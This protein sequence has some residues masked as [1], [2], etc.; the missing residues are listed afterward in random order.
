MRVYDI[1]NA[2][3]KHRFM[4][5][6]HIVSNCGRIVQLQN[7]PQNKLKDLDLVHGIVRDGDFDL[8]EILYE[9]PMDL[10]SQLIRTSFIARKGK[11]F[12]VADY[13]AIEA[14]VIA[15]LA[16]EE[17]KLDSFRNGEDIYCATASRMFNVPVVKNGVNGELRKKGK[18]AEL[19]CI[20]EGT[21]IQTDR[22][23][24]PIQ[25]LT[26]QDLVYDGESYV[27]HGGLIDKGIKE[28][29]S[30][31]QLSATADHLVWIE[32]QSEPVPFGYA[33]RTNAR[34][35]R[36]DHKGQSLRKS[37]NHLGSENIHATEDPKGLRVALCSD[38]ML[39]V[40]KAGVDIPAESNQ[41]PLNGLPA[42]HANPSCAEV[43]LQ[44]S[45]GA[46]TTMRKPEGKELQGLR[47]AGNKIQIHE[48]SGRGLVDNGESRTASRD[49]A[50]QDR[51]Q[52]SLRAGEYSIPF[53]CGQQH[54]QT[55]DRATEME[56]AR[57]AVCPNRGDPYANRGND[58][59]PNHRIGENS[60]SRKTQELANHS[61]AVRVYDILNCG[62]NNRYL[63]NGVLVHN[64]GYQGAVG[65]M[66]KMGGEEMGLTEDEMQHI[67][68]VWRGSN[69]KIT[70]LW[71][72][73]ENSAKKAIVHPGVSITIQHGITFQMLDGTL[74]V[75]LPSGRALAY[76]K[77][78]I[79]RVGMRSSIKYMGQTPETKKWETVD[80]Y[81]GKITENITQAVA[82]DCLGAA[83]LR[84]DKAGYR[85][86]FHVHDEVIVEVDEGS[87]ESDLQRIREI[88]RLDGVEWLKGL[89]LNAEGYITTYYRKD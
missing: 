3:D 45:L 80:T 53:S 62:P 16:G 41:R 26:T 35:L 33:A 30:Y 19:A 46:E 86:C 15:W 6:G 10:F 44:E 37:E 56:S 84:L 73:T 78:R 12:A 43:A 1:I 5:N 4:A 68:N 32:G 71:R 22:G 89:P 13:S 42:L 40:R 83:M 87:A 36:P 14:R 54:K 72:T 61:T 7:L 79:E 17:W 64:C 66:K 55:H 24:I 63:A 70:E 48:C 51:Q 74:Y 69:G 31:D 21:L 25:D 59:K 52:R 9:S 23:L 18:I 57:V 58:T 2:G 75:T 20:A 67:V 50:G 82:R 27:Q 77:A 85:V 76:Q 28:V 81:G 65:A 34:L 11:T 88:M 8:L 60:R 29:I 49:G 38:G 39:V 47:R